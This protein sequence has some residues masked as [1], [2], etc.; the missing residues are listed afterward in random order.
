MGIYDIKPDDTR[1]NEQI[2]IDTFA[3][4]P[5][6]CL[7]RIVKPGS[8]HDGELVRQRFE[9]ET[10]RWAYMPIPRPR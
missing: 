7:L 3:G 8:I 4:R 9:S 6:E 5:G 2:V 1:S 10:N